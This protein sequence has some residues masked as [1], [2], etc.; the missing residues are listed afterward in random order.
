M[1]PPI[2]LASQSPARRQLLKAAGIPHRVQP[3]YFDESQIK[4]SDPVELVQK[5]AAAKAEVVAAQQREPVLVV[6]A[7]S[8]LYLDGEILGKPANALEAERRLRQM[9]GEVG[10]LY[11]GHALIDTKQN[12]RLTHYAVTRVFFAKPSDEEIRAYVATGEPLNC[13]GCF[14]IDGRGSLFVERIEGCPGNVIGLSLPL[15]RRMMQELGY[16][17]TNAWS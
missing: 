11:T 17:L 5:L 12:R 8:V 4:S 9:R 13:A 15:L 2:V 6:G 10:E 1:L 3:S 7:D 16:S 14:A